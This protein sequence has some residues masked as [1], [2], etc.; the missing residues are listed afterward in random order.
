MDMRWTRSP[1]TSTHRSPVGRILLLSL[2]LMLVWGLAACT[3]TGTSAVTPSPTA[4]PLTSPTA[5][6]SADGLPTLAPESGWHTVLA[7]GNTSGGVQSI[8]GSFIAA[9]PY[10]IFFTCGG[11]GKIMVTYGATNDA[12]TQTAPCTATP[13]V[14]G[15]Q[16][17]PHTPGSQQVQVQVNTTGQVVWRLLVAL[18]D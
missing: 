14:N 4:T 17:Q 16:G 6:G 9:K 10:T 7:L 12:A 13:E 15:V 5:T 18:Q 8:G 1:G 2:S 3:L 11:A